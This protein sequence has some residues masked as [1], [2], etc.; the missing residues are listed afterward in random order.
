MEF[1][2]M[3]RTLEEVQFDTIYHEHF[4]YLSLLAAEPVLRRHGLRPFDVVELSTHGG[5]LRLM[6]CHADDPRPDGPTLAKV[7]ADEAAGALHD[8]GTYESFATRVERCRAGLLDFLAGVRREGK[9]IAAY[10][11]AAKGNTLLNYCGL[12]VD[13]IPFVVDLNPHKQGHLLPG[14]HLPVH[15]PDRIVAARPDYVLILPWNLKHEIMGQMDMVRAWG[16]R[17]VVAIPEI[18][19]FD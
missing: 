17:F 8:P 7:R 14:S 4:C 3:L 16:G 11:A 15:G 9:T 13:D 18:Q 1:P 12:T 19:V 6:A 2:H 5:S 10:G